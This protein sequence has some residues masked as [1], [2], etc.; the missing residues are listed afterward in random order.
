MSRAV[1][2]SSRATKRD[3]RQGRQNQLGGRALCCVIL[4]YHTSDRLVRIT[5]SGVH[6]VRFIVRAFNAS[7]SQLTPKGNERS[8]P[9]TTS[10]RGEGRTVGSSDFPARAA[11]TE[12]VFAQK[13]MD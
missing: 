3:D 11:S 8:H 10:G 4:G 6:H 9:S 5:L 7:L 13:G 1:D 2:Q 12:A